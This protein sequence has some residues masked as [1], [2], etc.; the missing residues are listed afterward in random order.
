MENGKLPQV[1]Q[2]IRI[3]GVTHYRRVTPTGKRMWINTHG[4][5]RVEQFD[6]VIGMAGELK[7]QQVRSALEYTVT[8]AQLAGGG[9]AYDGIWP[10]GWYVEATANN[11]D[12]VAFYVE[13]TGSFC[14][15]YY[16]EPCNITT[17]GANVERDVKRTL[18]QAQIAE[19]EAELAALG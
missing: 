19:L 13:G 5:A 3:A 9:A 8:K 4:R 12:K 11:G 18:I 14:K 7:A 6:N 16:V 2:V 17:P 10:D 15:E 1:G